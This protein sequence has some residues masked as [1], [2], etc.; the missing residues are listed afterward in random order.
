MQL[1][2]CELQGHP[3]DLSVS[4]ARVQ[5][6]WRWCLTFSQ[7]LHCKCTCMR[8]AHVHVCVCVWCVHFCV[9]FVCILSYALHSMLCILRVFTQFLVS[10]N[11]NQI[12][13]SHK[14]VLGLLIVAITKH[15]EHYSEEQP[16][17]V[18][19]EPVCWGTSLLLVCFN[20][21]RNV[22]VY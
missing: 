19:A 12:L 18:Q 11:I 15:N 21:K 4:F 5:V 10:S 6:L 8:F 3:Q 17:L 20:R 14:S 2:V 16:I 1:C 9:L 7:Y 22:D 13:A